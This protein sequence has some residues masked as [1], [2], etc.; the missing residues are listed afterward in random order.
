MLYSHIQYI[1]KYIFRYEIK[2]PLTNNIYF[3][4]LRVIHEAI[5][6][7]QRTVLK[8]IGKVAQLS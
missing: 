3:R 8:S 7:D 4:I 2:K 1:I 6:Y 5:F